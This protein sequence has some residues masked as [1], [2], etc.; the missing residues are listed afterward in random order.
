MY[1]LFTELVARRHY[2]FGHGIGRSGD[3]L[4]AQ[5]KAVGST[6]LSQ[7]TNALL[8]NLI[9]VMGIQNCRSCFLV[10]MATGMTLTLCFLSLK[11][12]RPNA[13][14]I[15]WSRID[16][17]SCFKSVTTPGFIPIVINTTRDN[18]ERGCLNTNIE[19][20][21]TKL[22]TL[23]T[24]EILC[25]MSTTSCFAP[26]NMDN[27]IELANMAKYFNIPHVINNAYG[28]QSTYINSYIQKAQREGRVDLFVQSS[29][30]NLM[31]PVGGAIVAG[32]DK[33]VVHA[34]AKTYAG[35]LYNL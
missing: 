26:R 24:E 23:N 12:Q 5:P 25:I 31:V 7:L 19:E 14:Y 15:L 17:K 18:N 21:K 8:L 13:K 6:I 3:L 22:S 27:I 2:N 10:P 11:K 1:F 33:D 29:D 32:F 30:K 35:N 4:E 28:L 16:Q 34:V 20:F 9:R